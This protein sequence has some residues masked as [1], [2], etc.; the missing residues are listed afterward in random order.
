VTMI[1]RSNQQGKSSKVRRAANEAL[2]ARQMLSVVQEGS[3]VRV[4]GTAADDSIVISRDPY[5]K[6]TLRISVNGFMNVVSERG[7]TGISVEGL[8]G[9]DIILVDESHGAVGAPVNMQ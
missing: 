5:L 7:L 4:T 2:E 8:N 9:N 3:I 1:R 6:R